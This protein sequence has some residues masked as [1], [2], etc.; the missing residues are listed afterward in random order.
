MSWGRGGGVGVSGP[1]SSGGRAARSHSITHL[2][3]QIHVGLLGL[4]DKHRV[5]YA[6]L[7]NPRVDPLYP[8][9][10]EIPLLVLQAL[11]KG[12]AAKLRHSNQVMPDSCFSYSA[13][14][15]E[16]QAMALK[17]ARQHR[18]TILKKSLLATHAQRRRPEQQE[19]FYCNGF[20]PGA[21]RD[22]GRRSHRENTVGWTLQ[23]GKS[24][25]TSAMRKIV[26]TY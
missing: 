10:A 6:V 5:R 23:V 18:P 7:T 24:K 4:V 20:R 15:G 11:K 19:F 22:L 17:G 9:P 13:G 14:R 1:P 2:S 3:I 8:Q 26:A 25:I 12:N 21:S 16:R